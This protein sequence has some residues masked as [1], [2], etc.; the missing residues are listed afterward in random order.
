MVQKHIKANTAIR[1]SR[2]RRISNRCH[3]TLPSDKFTAG[4][5]SILEIHVETGSA[6]DINII[7]AGNGSALASFKMTTDNSQ[8]FGWIKII[9]SLMVHPQTARCIC[10]CPVSLTRNCAAFTAYH[11]NILIQRTDCSIKATQ[12][13]ITTSGRR[14]NPIS[15]HGT[16]LT[17]T[18]RTLVNIYP[19]I[20]CRQ[21]GP[22]RSFDKVPAD[23]GN[24]ASRSSLNQCSININL[25]PIAQKTRAGKVRRGCRVYCYGR[26]A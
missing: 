12:K 22:A 19:C 21:S 3:T 2:S 18:K 4:N 10:F 24:H 20:L 11:S 15:D 16:T 25:I 6:A 1:I 8:G 14:R 7:L 23:P 5:Y 13:T 26:S 9:E 17:A